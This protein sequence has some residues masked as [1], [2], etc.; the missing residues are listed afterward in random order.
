MVGILAF[1]CTLAPARA[2]EGPALLRNDVE[3]VAGVKQALVTFAG[4]HPATRVMP[5]RFMIIEQAVGVPKAH[6][7][8]TPYLRA[9]VEEMKASGFVAKSL[10]ASGQT[11]ASVAPASK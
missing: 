11:D 5:G 9:F 1:C 3:T 4:T 6:D 8:A 7:A 10:A 2:D